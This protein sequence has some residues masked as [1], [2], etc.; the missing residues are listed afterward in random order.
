MGMYDRFQDPDN[1][2]A[3]SYDVVEQADKVLTR[4]DSL[5]SKHPEL[6]K[7]LREIYVTIVEL[8]DYIDENV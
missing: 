5:R 4:I 3:W 7:D 1:D 6:E 8:L 2:P